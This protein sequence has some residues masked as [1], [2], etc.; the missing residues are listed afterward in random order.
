MIRRYKEL[1][2]ANMKKW[3]LIRLVK[4]YETEYDVIDKTKSKL[5]KNHRD[6]NQFIDNYLAQKE[7]YNF[8][9]SVEDVLERVKKVLNNQI[10]KENEGK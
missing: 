7:K 3:D 8:N 9:D 4:E 5:S 1:T 10:E 6:T 2:M